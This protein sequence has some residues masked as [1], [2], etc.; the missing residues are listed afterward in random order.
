MAMKRDD[1]AALFRRVFDQN[2]RALFGYALR[3]TPGR[4]DAEDVVSETFTVV[5]RRFSKL[6]GDEREQ[7]L[8]LYG[9]ARKVLSNQH[10][11]TAR[12]SRL[13][14]RIQTR[15]PG[16]SPAADASI[17]DSVD[18]AEALDALD[19]LNEKDRE[20]VTLAL[21][22]ELTNAEI[23]KATGTSVA[24]V[25]VR[26][27]RAKKRLRRQFERSVQERPRGGHVSTRRATPDR[28]QEETG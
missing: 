6:P 13:N 28:A 10:R 12:A 22:E 16:E 21:W 4:V 9:I 5:W 7:R 24:N 20:L 23:A 25:S 26:L 15:D 8:W 27:H 3:R 18:I 2:Y 11:S 14:Q 19:A 17:E 1:D